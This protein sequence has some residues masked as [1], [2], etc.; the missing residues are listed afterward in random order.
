LISPS[1]ELLVFGGAQKQNAELSDAVRGASRTRLEP[2]LHLAS[3]LID[4]G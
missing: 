4:Y 2:T 1:A 3:N